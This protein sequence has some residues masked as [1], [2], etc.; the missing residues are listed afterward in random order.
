MFWF[1]LLV[2]LLGCDTWSIFS[3]YILAGAACLRFTHVILAWVFFA[4]HST[5]AIELTW[6]DVELDQF[7]SERTVSTVWLS[8]A[9]VMRDFPLYFFNAGSLLRMSH[10]VRWFDSRFHGG[11]FSIHLLGGAPSPG[12]SED[13]TTSGGAVCVQ[14]LI[15]E[16]F[17]GPRI[18]WTSFFALFGRVR[19]MCEND[20][21][22]HSYHSKCLEVYN[23][24]S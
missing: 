5:S 19:R 8:A 12:A 17:S 1:K 16:D 3:N 24:C 2:T 14:R 7:K 10:E 4:H 23:T 22:T 15:C 13:P 6:Q 18:L 21:P 20:I 11:L 9:S